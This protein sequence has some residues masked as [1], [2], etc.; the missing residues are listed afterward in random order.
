MS[1]NAPASAEPPQGGSVSGQ[2]STVPAGQAPS[3]PSLARRWPAEWEPQEAIWL[4]WPHNESTWPGLY[5]QIPA[6][7]AALVR[8]ACQ[9]VPVR[10]LAAG[11][12]ATIVN[13][14]LGDLVRGGELE[15]FDIPTN[16]CWIRDYGPTF[17]VDGNRLTGI[18]W[19]F[20]AWGGKYA[21]WDD[22]AAAARR[23]CESIGVRHEASELGLEGGAIEGDGN[24]RL[25][26]TPSCV[27]VE[28]R[29]HGWSREQI[30][31]ELHRRLGVHEVV[32][33]DGGG[34]EGDDT[35]GHIDQLAR[36][37]NPE[38][39]VCAVSG[40]E[41]VNH[42]G[43]ELNFSQL[44]D[45]ARKTTPGV[46]VHRLPIPPARRIETARVPESY[47]NFLMLGD[48]AVLVPTFR[49]PQSDDAALGLLR[50][51]LPGRA[52][53]PVDAYHFAWGLGAW[54]CASQQQPAPPPF[55]S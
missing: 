32:W 40:P 38:H 15:I 37:V 26:V 9:Y 23:I 44:L 7:F 3:R 45:W 55:G 24:G 14:E 12:L 1:A 30:Q 52:I 29:N 49:Q 25:L 6:A 16:D 19:R 39:V 47:T 51:L 41:D 48:R 54:H 22:D 8:A 34:L 13:R 42:R 43:L 21:P 53:V 36:F 17:V 31:V 35:D 10:L 20:N 28:T 4:S 46:T 33:I 27:V 18:D 11:E 2:S 5:E 50:E